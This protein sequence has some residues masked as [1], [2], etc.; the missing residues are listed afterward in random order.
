MWLEIRATT[1]NTISGLGL[2][3]AAHTRFLFSVPLPAVF[4]SNGDASGNS[5]R[6]PTNKQCSDGCNAMADAM[7][8]AIKEVHTEEGKIKPSHL[9]PLV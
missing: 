8:D 4:T 1:R 5:T 9:K 6:I 2:A 3:T 7:A